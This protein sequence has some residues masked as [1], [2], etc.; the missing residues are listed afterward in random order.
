[1]KFSTTNEKTKRFM[2]SGH[3]WI[4]DDDG[5]VDIFAHSHGETHNGPV[6]ENCGY[7]KCWHCNPNPSKCP[8]VTEVK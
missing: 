7:R 5:T 1:M 8:V 3:Q 4:T 2:A 6:C